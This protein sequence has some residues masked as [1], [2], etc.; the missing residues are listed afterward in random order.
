M[1]GFVLLFQEHTTKLNVYLSISYDLSK[2]ET[3]YKTVKFV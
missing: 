2:Y 1:T 3:V